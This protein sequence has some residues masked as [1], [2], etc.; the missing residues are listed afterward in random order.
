MYPTTLGKPATM[1]AVQTRSPEI[2]ERHVTYTVLSWHGNLFS[3]SILTY[4]ARNVDE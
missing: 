1:L 3:V 4:A 2:I